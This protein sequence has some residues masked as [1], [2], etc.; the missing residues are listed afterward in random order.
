MQD[1]QPLGWYA[2]I[3]AG[4]C[5]AYLIY[6]RWRFNREARRLVK[7]VMEEHRRTHD[8]CPHCWAGKLLSFKDGQLSS[9]DCPDC[10]GKGFIRKS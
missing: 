4:L 8:Q 10:W 9:K 2:L 3:G 7:S 5:A 6:E 1:M